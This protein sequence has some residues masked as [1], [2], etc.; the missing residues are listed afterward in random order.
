MSKKAKVTRLDAQI[1]TSLLLK[2]LMTIS[3][4]DCRLLCLWSGLTEEENEKRMTDTFGIRSKSG[5]KKGISLNVASFTSDVHRDM[6][7]EG[8]NE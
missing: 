2:M 3:E 7:K 5:S 4:M 8:I 6:L 1:H